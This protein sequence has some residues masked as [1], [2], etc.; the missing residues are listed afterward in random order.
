M[1]SGRWPLGLDG[2][3]Q[4]P[5]VVAEVAMVVVVVVVIVTVAIGAYSHTKQIGTSEATWIQKGD[6]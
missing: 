6:T 1:F 3:T 2:N 5:V 4:N